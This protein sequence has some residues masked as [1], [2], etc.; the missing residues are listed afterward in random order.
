MANE[1]LW[2]VSKTHAHEY[3]VP[4]LFSILRKF[5]IKKEALILD[6]GCGAGYVMK[7]LYDEGFNNIYGFDLSESGIRLAKESYPQI[8]D[9]Y[10]IHDCYLEKLPAGI[11]ESQFDTVLSI[12]VV[13]HLYYPARYQKNI[14]KWL[15]TGGLLIISTPYH[16]YLKNLALSIL[17]KWD[18]HFTV[19]WEGGHV[20]F[21]SKKTLSEMLE[22]V[23]FNVEYFTGVGRIPF[24]WKSM[25]IVAKK[26]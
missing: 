1:Y 19:D 16:G 15:K 24:L 18:K 8:A 6:A 5:N 14:Y 11:P 12:E 9:R 23:G 26:P 10:F 25:M 13:E 22:K 17:N 21:F 7:R 20:K 4:A 2:T 3:L